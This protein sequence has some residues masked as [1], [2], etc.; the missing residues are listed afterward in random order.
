MH[1][2]AVNNSTFP[3]SLSM[4]KLI[5]ALQHL[6]WCGDCCVAA[7]PCAIVIIPTN[8]N[9]V[10]C[11]R[12]RDPHVRSGCSSTR[13]TVGR[14]QGQPQQR[15]LAITIHNAWC[16]TL[17]LYYCCCATLAVL[18]VYEKYRTARAI[19]RCVDKEQAFRQSVAP[20]KPC[21]LQYNTI[22]L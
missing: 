7:K 5:V 12:N 9:S 13:T 14:S 1:S 10:R 15:E 16:A 22:I 3:T 21:R 6:C 8:S 11:A 2:K 20:H 17:L 4:H 18:S 19:T